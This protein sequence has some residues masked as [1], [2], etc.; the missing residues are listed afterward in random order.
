MALCVPMTQHKNKTLTIQFYFKT[1]RVHLPNPTYPSLSVVMT[2]LNLLFVFFYFY[3][4]Y[5][6]LKNIC[7]SFAHF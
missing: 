1:S 5:I 2:F 3:Y 7:S 6:A 4:E